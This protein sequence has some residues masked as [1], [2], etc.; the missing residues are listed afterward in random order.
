MET[1]RSEEEKKYGRTEVQSSNVSV[2]FAI[3]AIIECSLFV[4]CSL[5]LAYIFYVNKLWV[6]CTLHKKI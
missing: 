4:D 2:T 3:I 6:I 1:E 5:H